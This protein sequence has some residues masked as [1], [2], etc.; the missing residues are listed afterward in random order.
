[1]SNIDADLTA[2]LRRAE[3]AQAEVG[4]EIAAKRREVEERISREERAERR[5]RLIADGVP[6]RSLLALDASRE[7]DA[8]RAARAFVDGPD[9]CGFLILAGTKGTGKT[10]AAAWLCA[11]RH[12]TFLDVARLCRINRYDE[13]QMRPLETCRLLV[14]DDLGQEFSDAKGSFAATLDG[15]INARYGAMLKTVITTNLTADDFKA[16]YGERVADR[17]RE[18]G[19]FIPVTGE[20]MRSKP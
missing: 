17:I 2:I 8:I 5:K 12:G 1:V 10:V 14:L 16:R 15:I 4:D 11:E 3:E 6:L 18:C 7:T 9:K 19:R 20:S 13:A